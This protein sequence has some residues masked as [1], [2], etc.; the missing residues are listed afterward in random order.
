MN[1][2]K[3]GEIA[4]NG[5]ECLLWATGNFSLERKSCILFNS[6]SV[7]M[8]EIFMIETC[9]IPLHCNLPPQCTR[10]VDKETT[11]GMLVNC[12]SFAWWALGSTLFSSVNFC[13]YF[14][15]SLSCLPSPPPK[16]CFFKKLAQLTNIILFQSIRS[17]N[18]RN[19]LLVKRNSGD[20]IKETRREAVCT[21]E[22]IAAVVPFFPRKGSTIRKRCRHL[23]AL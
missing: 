1:K 8:F 6:V 11:Q 19:Q 9:L 4:E 20:W 22:F 7:G 15:A 2:R 23:V 21:G 17:D 18:E 16:K 5:Y 13:V 12:W 14:N 3:K 10:W